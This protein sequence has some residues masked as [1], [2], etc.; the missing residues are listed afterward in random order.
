L[1]DLAVF[2][3]ASEG[4]KPLDGL[5]GHAPRLSRPGFA[6]RQ[7]NG[8]KREFLGGLSSRTSAQGGLAAN[9]DALESSDQGVQ[10]Q[11]AFGVYVSLQS[12]RILNRSPAIVSNDSLDASEE[13]GFASAMAPDS[14]DPTLL[15]VLVLERV[16]R[17]K[18]MARFYVL[19]IEPTLFDDFALLRRWGRIGNA[20]PERIDLHPSR[21]VAQTELTKWLDR[22][23]RRGYQLRA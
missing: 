9:I 1:F 4:L 17:A 5:L 16:D 21:R 20:E 22:K 18:N 19:S 3:I 14:D 7:R 12:I 13:F 6:T 2:L 23:R 8:R 11:S 15:Q 10:R